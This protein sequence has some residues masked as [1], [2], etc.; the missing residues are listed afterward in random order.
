[1]KPRKPA[2]IHFLVV[3]SVNKRWVRRLLCARRP[4]STG[5]VTTTDRE[6]VTCPICRILL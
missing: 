2:Q 5:H 1:M 4:P 3:R 6:A